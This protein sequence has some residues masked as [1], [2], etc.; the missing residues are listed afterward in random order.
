MLPM[1]TRCLMA[2]RAE[3]C[4]PKA[5]EGCPVIIIPDRIV[6]PGT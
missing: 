1:T 2:Y 5:A 4:C 6:L 3:A